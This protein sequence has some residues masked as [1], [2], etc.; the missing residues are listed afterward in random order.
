MSEAPR[1]ITRPASFAGAPE[2]PLPSSISRSSTTEFVVES[3]VVVPLT[4]RLPV[5]VAS[6]EI[7]TSSGSPIVTVLFVTAVLTSLAVP[8]NTRVS[9]PT[10]TPSVEEPS[11]IVK[12][13]PP[14]LICVSTYAFV[15]A[16]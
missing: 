8:A 3:V 5:T 16:C 14:L 4:V 15:A 12:V 1:S 7:V 2:V 11:P 13:P 6:P 10:T 9:V